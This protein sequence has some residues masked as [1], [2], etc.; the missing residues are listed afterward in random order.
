MNRPMSELSQA[1]EA[2]L[3]AVAARE[4]R[5]EPV[6]FSVDYGKAANG[7]SPAIEARIDRATR[8]LIFAS[9]FARLDDGRT[10][11]TASAVYRVADN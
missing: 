10:A 1:L 3:L 4:R 6:C 8:S 5:V 9:A 11:A 2:A 7:A